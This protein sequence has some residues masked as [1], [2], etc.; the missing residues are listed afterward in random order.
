MPVVLYKGLDFW[1]PEN[2]SCTMGQ[3]GIQGLVHKW[4]ELLNDKFNVDILETVEL[5]HRVSMI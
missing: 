5:F 4:L 2:T 1:V 3:P